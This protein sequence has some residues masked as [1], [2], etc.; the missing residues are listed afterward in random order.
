MKIA[1]VV[2]HINSEASGPSY[3]VPSL[4]RH[5]DFAGGEVII[6][7]IKSGKFARSV[8]EKI[9]QN[10]SRISFFNNYGF[11]LS[12][13]KALINGKYD[14]YHSHGIWHFTSLFAHIAA[15]RNIAPHIISPRGMLDEPVLK[16]SRFKKKIIWALF[17]NYVLKECTAFHATSMNEA[18]AIRS[19][20]FN[21]PIIIL[22]NG[23][24]IT[25]DEQ[26]KNLLS[27]KPK[28]QARYCLSLGRIHPK[29]NLKALIIAF[30]HLE[31]IIPDC[32]LK[33]VGPNEG[34]HAE[35]LVQLVNKLQ[36]S[37]RVQIL[38]AV[39][40]DEKK[41]LM[42]NASLFILPTFSEN[43]AMTVAESLELSTPVICSTGAPWEKIADIECGDWVDPDPNS[44]AESIKAYFASS[45]QFQKESGQR[46]RQWMHKEFSWSQISKSMFEEY[47]C[48][49]KKLNKK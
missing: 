42:A 14:I 1:H 19:L 48:I 39:F 3:S 24:D 7:C 41:A 12:L 6:H 21:Q 15:K 18:S 49:L 38:P 28:Y 11:S 35:E 40:G 4:A 44:L 23:I 26:L 10:K 36:L 47:S 45:T 2:T 43:F 29:K 32:V 8:Y 9:I 33:I 25:T 16:Y 31:K 20:G 30:A 46:G 17:Q 37:N 13:L 5:L 27:H 34:S 22:P